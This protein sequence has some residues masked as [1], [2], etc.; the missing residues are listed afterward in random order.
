M[1]ASSSNRP[2]RDVQRLLTLSAALSLS[3]SRLEDLH[4]EHQLGTVLNKLLLGK[5]NR[6]IETAL[7]FLF[8]NDSNAYEVL[9]EQAET[10]SESASVQRNGEHFDALLIS[11]PLVAWTRYQLP[12]AP[13][14]E[15]AMHKL[16]QALCEQILA[17][18][19]KLA[20]LPDLVS[21]E[22]MPQTFQDTRHWTQSLAMRA[23]DASAPLPAT[24]GN[25]ADFPDNL[26]ADARFLVGV[27]VVPRGEAIFR[28]QTPLDDTRFFSREEC[29]AG[30]KQAAEAVLSPVFAGCQLN[31][32]PVDAYYVNNRE[33][34]RHIRPLALKAAV[35]W[36]HTAA[37]L[38]ASDLRACIAG[39]G[40]NAIEE[41]RVGFTTRS[42]HQV[43]YGCIWP[44]LSKEEALADTM[45]TGQ[46][47]PS[48]EIAAMLKESGITEIRRL[49]GLHP[50]EFCEDCGAPYFPNSLGEFM[51]PELPEETETGPIHFH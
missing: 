50:V 42:S 12:Q 40:E 28:W 4:W 45:D 23:L 35:T 38:P 43:V 20:T 6:S 2:S 36:L 47:S 9:V 46:V 27:V 49:P 18:G 44:V 5:K 41:Y 30:W 26:L 31:L 11:A 19:V 21:F 25:Q 8:S 37:N 22:Q 16:Q 33:A 34:D 17:P 15:E 3:G 39:C 24:F 13:L 7:D 48:D 29:N 10:F 1:P 32:L 51:H 14:R